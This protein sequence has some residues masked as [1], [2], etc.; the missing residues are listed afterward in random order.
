MA[1]TAAGTDGTIAVTSSSSGTVQIIVDIVGV[2]L[3]AYPV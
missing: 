1:M 3:S 2:V